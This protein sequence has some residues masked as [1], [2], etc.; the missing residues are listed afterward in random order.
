[1]K[2]AVNLGG[3]GHVEAKKFAEKEERR[4]AHIELYG[5]SETSD[6]DDDEETVC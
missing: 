2:V 4:R 1:L 5:D 3:K 6:S